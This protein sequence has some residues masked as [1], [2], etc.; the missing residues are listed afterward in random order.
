M[1]NKSSFVAVEYCFFL[2]LLRKVSIKS[3]L[4]VLLSEATN[5]KIEELIEHSGELYS[6]FIRLEDNNSKNP[7]FLGWVFKGELFYI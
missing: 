4:K 6:L 7:N 5:S 2:A 3:I 1:L